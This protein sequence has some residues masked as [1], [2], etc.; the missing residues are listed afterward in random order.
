MVTETTGVR[1]LDEKLDI[2]EPERATGTVEVIDVRAYF[3]D[4]YGQKHTLPVRVYM[5]IT[6]FDKMF[7]PVRECNLNSTPQ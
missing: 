3:L 6:E 4:F 7:L 5:D 2:V 1:F